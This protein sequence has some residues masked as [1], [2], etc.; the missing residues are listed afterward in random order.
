MKFLLIL[1]VLANIVAGGVIYKRYESCETLIK[2]YEIKG[3][4]TEIQVECEDTENIRHLMIC[5]NIHD[6][7]NKKV[8]CKYKVENIYIISSISLVACLCIM[9]ILY[10]CRELSK[11]KS[12]DD[13]NN[14]NDISEFS[15]NEFSTIT[16]N[17]SNGS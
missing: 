13:N 3:L 14:I 11:K 2:K 17:A 16:K 6:N 12:K 5:N 1:L 10:I 8:S 9:V 7:E 15:T 4:T